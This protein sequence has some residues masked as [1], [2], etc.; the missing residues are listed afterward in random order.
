[1]RWSPIA[2]AFAAATA[3]AAS[4]DVAQVTTTDASTSAAADSAARPGT[5]CGLT[6]FRRLVPKLSAQAEIY[7]PGSTDF[8]TLSQR[9]SNLQPPTVNVEVVPASEADVVEIVGITGTPP[10]LTC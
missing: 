1:M 10:R 3:T 7:Y 4:V 6:D 9:W 8:A 5:Y 2:W